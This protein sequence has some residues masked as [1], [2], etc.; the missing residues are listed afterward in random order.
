MNKTRCKQCTHAT[1]EATVYPCCKCAEIQMI[2]EE[3]YFIDASKN[4]M[5]GE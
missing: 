4:L 3:N 5:K 2:K 1:K